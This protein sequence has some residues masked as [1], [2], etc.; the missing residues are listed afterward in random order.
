MYSSG[1]KLFQFA[2]SCF[3]LSHGEPSVWDHEDRDV[4]SYFPKAF[5]TLSITSLFSGVETLLMSVEK[6]AIS[7]YL[8]I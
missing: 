1:M 3:A 8:W 6:L 7:P 2:F 5:K 4:A